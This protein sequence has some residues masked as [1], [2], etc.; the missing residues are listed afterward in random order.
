MY[1]KREY[2]KPIIRLK[3]FEENVGI[4]NLVA[5]FAKKVTLSFVA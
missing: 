3:S 4:C 5:K 2:K 1:K